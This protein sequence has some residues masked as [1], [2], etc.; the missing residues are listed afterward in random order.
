MVHTSSTNV[1]GPMSQSNVDR[2]YKFFELEI[3]AKLKFIKGFFFDLYT[4]S[5]E[6]ACSTAI[7]GAKD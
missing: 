2:A 7:A 5:P 3:R 1:L 6:R 4:R